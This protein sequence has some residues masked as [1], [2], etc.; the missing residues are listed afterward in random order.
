MKHRL[1]RKNLSRI[2]IVSW[3]IFLPSLFLILILFGGPKVT[4]WGGFF[5][6]L[7]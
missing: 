7:I 3:G 1:D 4:L 5:V 2:L 6:N